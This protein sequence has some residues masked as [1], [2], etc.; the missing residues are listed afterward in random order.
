VDFFSS[1]I[2]SGS[3]VL[4]FGFLGAM[5]GIVFHQLLQG[6]S[7]IMETDRTGQIISDGIFHLAVSIALMVGGVLLWLAGKPTDISRGIRALIGGF[8]IGGGTFNL[9]G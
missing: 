6:H 1:L 3:F 2:T 7:V 9:R 5:D 8:L 4:G